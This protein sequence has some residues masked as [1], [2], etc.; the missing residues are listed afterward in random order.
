MTVQKASGTRRAPSIRWKALA[1]PLPAESRC[2]TVRCSHPILGPRTRSS[3][4]R[5]EFPSALAR[6]LE[7]PESG[8]SSS[9][10]IQLLLPS[11]VIAANAE[12]NTPS[13]SRK[14]A[15]AWPTAVTW[16]QTYDRT[17]A[18]SFDDRVSEPMGKP[19][20]LFARDT[21]LAETLNISSLACTP[22]N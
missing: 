15:R 10:A 9:A 14:G 20:G 19:A 21:R 4:E 17:S 1:A 8:S 11:G 13:Q 5:L 2:A 3:E 7:P 6:I 18:E 16:R 22:G 12:R